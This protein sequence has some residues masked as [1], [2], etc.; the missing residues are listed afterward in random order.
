LF[1]PESFM[2]IIAICLILLI[3]SNTTSFGQ[4]EEANLPQLRDSNLSIELVASGIESPTSMAFLGLDDILVLEKD[5]GTVQRI[6]NGEI[7][8]EPV[9]DVNVNGKDERGLLG[10]AVSK[11][12]S[13]NK[14]YVFLYYTEAEGAEDGGEPLANRLYRYEFVDNKLANPKLLL[15]LPYFPG[16]AHNGGVLTIGPDNN[17]YVAVGELTPTSY[18]EGDYKFLSQNYEDGEVPDGRGGILRI[19]QD[20]QL[21]AD[22][23]I[24]GDEHP[25]DL[26]YA[27]G[28]RNSFGIAFDPVTGN[29]WDTENGPSWGD[30]LNLVE[31][32]FNSGW[33]KV[34]GTWTVNELINEEGNREINK[35]EAPSTIPAGL[36]NFNGKGKYSPPELTWDETIAPTAIAFL[37]SDKLG[38]QYEND[39]FVGTVKDRLLH[40]KL[41]EPYRTELILNGTLNVNVFY[42]L[43]DTE[44]VTFAEGFGII[45]DVKVGPD[46]YLYIVSGAR[47][48]E[49][50]I[51]RILPATGDRASLE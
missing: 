6:V 23:G 38:M 46:G 29:L 17:V 51:Y 16:P 37:D 7:L 22:K 27:Y 15:D 4:E 11:N 20:G 31:P 18:A 30:E 45:T 33:A 1:V 36:I 40:F 5:K 13:A 43:E 8:E 48:P 19:T 28:I 26:Y 9:L 32:G 25:L 50:K 10:I 35:G 49:G 34:L 14:T 2:L 44:D 21:V 41:E 39:M 24:L 42:T 3:L 12:A 47:S